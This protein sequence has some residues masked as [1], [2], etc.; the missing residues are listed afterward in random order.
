M[1]NARDVAWIALFDIFQELHPKKL[2]PEKDWQAFLFLIEALREETHAENWAEID[3]VL[4]SIS[5]N[6]KTS[7]SEAWRRLYDALDKLW[8]GERADAATQ[9]ELAAHAGAFTRFRLF[10]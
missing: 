8:Q 3:R 6:Q 7:P 2:I 4:D 1:R 9:P 5:G 10:S